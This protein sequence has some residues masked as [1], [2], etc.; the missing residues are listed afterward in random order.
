VSRAQFEDAVRAYAFVD[1][2]LD[3]TA[4]GAARNTLDATGLLVVGEPHGMSETP[5]VVYA[6]ARD[7][8]IR[9]VAFEWSHEEMDTLDLDRL[10]S[11]PAASEFFSGDGRITAGHF[12]LLEQLQPEQVIAFDRLDADTPT[13]WQEHVRVRDREMAERLLEQW[14]RRLPLLVLTGAF[15]AQLAAAEGEP[16]AAHL[17]QALPGLQP[18]ML[19]YDGT[20]MPTAPIVFALPPGHPAVTPAYPAA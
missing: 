7:L 8:G 2:A 15:H 9:A 19:A 17:A 6:L 10:W 4:L 11:L 12:A 5:S 18:A 13:S 14:D 20:P 1:V 3:P 16:M